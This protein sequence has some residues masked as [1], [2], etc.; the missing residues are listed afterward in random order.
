[1]PVISSSVDKD[2]H[3]YYNRYMVITN[4]QAYEKA[5]KRIEKLMER[6]EHSFTTYGELSMVARA[7]SDYELI[8]YP[9]AKVD[10][11]DAL[12]FRMEQ[13]GHSLS[14]AATVMGI[15]KHH[16]SEVVNR[17]HKFSLSQARAFFK[18][19]IPAHTLLQDYTL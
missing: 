13:Y 11:I 15:S 7:V 1:M 12:K 3:I 5:L 14:E 17:K 8:H 6:E 9:Q 4:K 18:Y 19:G 16:L 2:V 10:P